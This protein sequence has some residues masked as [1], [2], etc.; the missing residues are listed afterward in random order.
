[1]WVILLYDLLCS[2]DFSCLALSFDLSQ[3]TSGRAVSITREQT[4]ADQP[5]LDGS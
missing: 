4:L 2:R 1:M 3:N 5:N